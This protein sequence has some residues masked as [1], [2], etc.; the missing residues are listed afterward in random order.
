MEKLEI[1][2]LSVHYTRSGKTVQA[3]RD[4]SLTVR[5][6]ETLGLVGE[7]GSGKSTVALAVL[8]LIR[9]QEGRIV[10]GQ[11]L[12]DGQDLLMLP[13]GTMRAI[14][15]RSI[16]MIF[17]DPFT[18]LNP[19]MTIRE[20]MAEAAK[21][22]G[23]SVSLEEALQHVQLEPARMLRAYPHQLSGGQRQRVL[24]ATALLMR[25][26]FLLADEPTTALDVLVQKDILEL[27]FRLQKELGM[28]MLFVSHNLGLVAQYTQRIAVMKDGQVVEEAASR[29]FPEPAAGLY[30]ET[31]RGLAATDGF[32][33][34]SRPWPPLRFFSKL[35]ALSKA[36]PIEGG[37]FRRRIGSVQAL[38]NVS[39]SVM[40]GETLAIVGASG[41]GKSTL[42]RLLVGLMPADSGE[43]RW[44]G[45]PLP[46]PRDRRATRHMQMIFQDPFA[47][48]NPKLTVGTQLG[49]VVKLSL[50]RG[51]VGRDPAVT[52]STAL[53]DRCV[54]LLD[55]V[56]LSADALAHYPFQFSG[57]Q[58][59]R[60]AIAR[61]LALEPQLLIADEPLSALDVTIQAQ[62]LSLFKALKERGLT[63]VFI[64]HDLAIVDEF[65]DRLLVL[66]DGQ[67]VEQGTTA[68]ILS[69]PKEPYTQ[70]LLKAIPKVYGPA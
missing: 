42:A 21:A 15:G 6:G 50:S 17:Q 62:M 11:V 7:S 59:Q 69:N 44:K 8:R 60:I 19:V 12:L 4:V 65:A 70:A 49:E 63:L 38:K 14:R 67:I 54:S 23:L 34:R 68:E 28:G 1:Q 13:E 48:L 30:P 33:L 24:I 37:I 2:N 26:A 64:T 53:R 10:H 56:G 46:W 66:Q 51:A 36:F 47:S 31:D 58:R 16:A 39:V 3:V 35:R 40:E 43:I 27:L 22:H 55:A 20:Q 57:G 25:P 52:K 45:Q 9:P 61:A 5:S 32:K 29:A 41:C 18:A